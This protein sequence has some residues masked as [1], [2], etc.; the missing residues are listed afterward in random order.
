MIDGIVGSNG[1]EIQ[2]SY[3]P[4]PSF[5]S[6]LASAGSLRYNGVTQCFE[7]YDGYTWLSIPKTVP[8]IGL[9]KEAIDAIEWANQQRKKEEKIKLLIGSNPVLKNLHDEAEIAKEK[10]DM[11]LALLYNESSEGQK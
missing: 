10:V 11:I 2:D 9:S 8:T 6:T 4:S 1:I 3:F 7:T 5:S